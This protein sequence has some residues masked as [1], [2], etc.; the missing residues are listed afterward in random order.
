MFT[1]I[2]NQFLV[3]YKL[4][5]INNYFNQ[6]LSFYLKNNTNKLP[7]GRWTLENCDDKRNIKI[8]MANEDHCGTCNKIYKSI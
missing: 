7:L 2:Y 1:K 3:Y 4:P 6:I 5:T 8:D